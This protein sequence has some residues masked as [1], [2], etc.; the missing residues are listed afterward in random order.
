MRVI[1][2]SLG[3]LFTCM[4]SNVIANDHLITIEPFPAFQDFPRVWVKP[5][6]DSMP[7]ESLLEESCLKAGM[8]YV[9]S[10][11]SPL[12]G[13][14]AVFDGKPILV[15]ELVHRIEN[16]TQQF[17]VYRGNVLRLMPEVEMRLNVPFDR[18]TESFL[19]QRGAHHIHALENGLVATMDPIALARIS[20]SRPELSALSKKINDAAQP[21]FKVS[22]GQDIATILHAWAVQQTPRWFVSYEA[23]RNYVVQTPL[24]FHAKNMVEAVQ[25]FFDDMPSIIGLRAE[26]GVDNRV[27]VIKQEGRP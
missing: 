14:S 26:V 7:L 18:Q 17:A 9:P 13:M 12:A 15:S 16:I 23:E 27:I 21:L 10:H 8:T 6:G 5:D 1:K 2:W 25:K 20:A 3:M 19:K 22:A 24:E 11:P 4:L